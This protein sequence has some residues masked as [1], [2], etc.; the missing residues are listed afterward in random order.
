MSFILQLRAFY[1]R[2]TNNSGSLKTKQICV[3]RIVEIKSIKYCEVFETVVLD[4]ATNL[5]PMETGHEDL[6]QLR[7]TA[8]EPGSVLSTK[9]RYM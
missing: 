5:Q 2:M 7:L 3:T 1:R 6:L 9:V 8:L 4:R